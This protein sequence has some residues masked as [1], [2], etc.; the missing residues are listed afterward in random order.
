MNAPQKA[1]EGGGLLG[2]ESIFFVET[3]AFHF[4]EITDQQWRFYEY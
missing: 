2:V 4:P 3:Q 1:G